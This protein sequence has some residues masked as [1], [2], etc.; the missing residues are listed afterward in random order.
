MKL[1][2]N[3]SP[4]VPEEA[5]WGHGGKIVWVQIHLCHMSMGATIMLHG[6]LIAQI[7]NSYSESCLHHY[8][9]SINQ[10]GQSSNTIVNIIYE[11][12]KLSKPMIINVTI[13]KILIYLFDC[14]RSWLWHEDVEPFAACRIFI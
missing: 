10:K 13:T 2:A 1:S 5:A 9:N 14:A 6:S 8:S 3:Q 12:Q 7:T 11:E 4:G